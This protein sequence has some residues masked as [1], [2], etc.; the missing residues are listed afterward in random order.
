MTNEEMQ[1]TME[2]ILKQ[3][4]NFAVNI[5]KLTGVMEQAD[6]RMTRLEGAFVGIFNMMTETAKAQKILTEQVSDL[7]VQ[8]IELKSAQA[9]TD[10]RLNAFINVVERYISE[11]RNGDARA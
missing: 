9:H 8:V 4:A 10:E 6:A 11:G 1:R 7:S 5:E 2:F 3:Q